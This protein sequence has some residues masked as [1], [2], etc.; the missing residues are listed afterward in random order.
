MPP[1]TPPPASHIVKPRL[2]WSRPLAPCEVGVRPNSPPQ[3]TS[4]SSSRP[5]CFRS[6]QQR[7]DRLVASCLAWSRWFED[8][9]VVVPRLAVAVIDLHHAHAAFRPAAVRIRQASANCAVAV[10]LARRRRLPAEVED[11]LRLESASGRPSPATA[12]RA[13]SW[14]VPAPRSA[15]CCSFIRCSRS[16]CSRCGPGRRLRIV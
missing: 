11:V 6:V 2:L 14:V 15:R 8:V 3:M 10:Q 12:M 1:L 9:A 5:R 4:V 16:S 7:R 13:S